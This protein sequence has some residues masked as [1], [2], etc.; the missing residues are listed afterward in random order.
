MAALLEAIEIKRK[1]FFE[2]EDVPYHCLDVEI[3]TPTARGGQ[4]LV[5]IKMRNLLT[6]AV[7]DKTFKAG[8]KFKEPD[9]VLTPASYLYSDG[10]GSHFMDQETYETHTL[11]ESLMGD[12]LSYLT[13]GLIV[14]IQKFNGNPIGL[15]MPTTVELEV[16]YTEPG[17]RGDTASGNV[18]KP[19]KLETG[20][21]IKVPLFIKEGE[22]VKVST[23]TGEFGGRA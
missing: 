18:T 21:E 2:L 8:D 10:E 15:Q 16:T 3:S 6:R 14:Q 9:L 5:R 1:M 4:T 20:I 13:E 22:K 17:A 12:A 7:F 23:E 19:A 11:G